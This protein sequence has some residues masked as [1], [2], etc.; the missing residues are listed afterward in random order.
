MI[1][2]L[3]GRAGR[4]QSESIYRNL[5]SLPEN[6]KAFVLVPDQFTYETEK[7]ILV[8][9]KADLRTE[10]LSLKRL[11]YRLEGECVKKEVNILSSEASAIL[12]KR[13][14]DLAADELTFFRN[15]CRTQGF[16]EEALEFI[17]EMKKGGV[18]LTDID[19]DPADG[20]NVKNKL[21]DIQ[22]IYEKYTSLLP[23][24][25]HAVPV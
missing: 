6:E 14:V 16:C 10:V 12:I 5:Q 17:D 20:E 1:K 9:K 2:F 22:K 7:N 23:E 24:D 19:I 21:S 3:T 25:S 11:A 8:N 15:V 4:K 18:D 13:A